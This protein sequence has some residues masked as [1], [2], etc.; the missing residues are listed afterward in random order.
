MFDF[1]LIQTPHS[2][3]QG[4]GSVFMLRECAESISRIKLPLEGHLLK[5]F[6]YSAIFDTPPLKE[7]ASGL[8]LEKNFFLKFKKM[9]FM[10]AILCE[11]SFPRIPEA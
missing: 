8:I 4:Q 1:R 3:N 10:R 5:K 11:K 2:L 9:T 6:F 7:S